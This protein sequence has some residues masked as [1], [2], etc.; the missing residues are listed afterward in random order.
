MVS[1]AQ[2]DGAEHTVL[3]NLVDRV[4]DARERIPI[5]LCEPVDRVIDARERI[6]IKL[7]EH[8]DRVIDVRERIPI[9]LRE[10]VDRLGVVN[11]KTFPMIVILSDNDLCTPRKIAGFDDSFT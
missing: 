5:K 11:R 3:G 7:R 10:P 9:K 2:I 4:I 8:V 1:V 6:P